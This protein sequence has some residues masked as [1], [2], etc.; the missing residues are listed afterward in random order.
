MLPIAAAVPAL[1]NPATSDNK[2]VLEI[3]FCKVRSPFLAARLEP[4]KPIIKTAI[5]ETNPVTPA[6]INCFFSIGA[7]IKLARVP[8]LTS[9][10]GSSWEMAKN[11]VVPGPA[12]LIAISSGSSA[13]VSATMLRERPILPVLASGTLNKPVSGSPWSNSSR[14][15]KLLSISSNSSSSW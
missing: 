9:T 4:T 11:A 2:R 3:S 7:L 8:C 1:D 13:L 10:S 14:S 5:A 6:V 12:S 15:K